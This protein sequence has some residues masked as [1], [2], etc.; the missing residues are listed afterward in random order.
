M[1]I[2]F[3]LTTDQVRRRI[4]TETR[5]LK[6]HK[7]VEA[8][9]R[10]EHP[11]LRGIVKGQGLKRGEHPEPITDIRVARAWRERLDAITPEA[12]T[13]EGFPGKNPAWFV[14]MFCEHNQCRRFD[15]IT[16]IS[17]EYPWRVQFDF[18]MNLVLAGNHGEASDY[19]LEKR[20]LPHQWRYISKC[21]DVLG[22][23]HF[24]VHKAGTF[25]YR[26]DA[27]EIQRAVDERIHRQ[28]SVFWSVSA[29]H[30]RQELNSSPFTSS[31]IIQS[32]SPINA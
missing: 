19:A 26:Y 11:V 25:F 24:N 32:I 13:R 23:S 29:E 5:R 3:A 8:S 22:H 16:V 10:G 20:W 14:N 7:L 17:Y 2:S 31:Y 15:E 18:L 12:V 21:Q 1:N 6:W 9:E 27:V 28:P 30:L 4:K